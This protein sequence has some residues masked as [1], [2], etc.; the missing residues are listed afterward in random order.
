MCSKDRWAKVYQPLLGLTAEQ[1]RGLL[2]QVREIRNGLAHFRHDVTADEH[3]ALRFCADWLGNHMPGIPVGW[4][5]ADGAAV[6][7]EA[8]E[9]VGVA[10]AMR[11]AL[12][13]A[14]DGTEP[15]VTPDQVATVEEMIDRAK[16]AM[17]AWRSG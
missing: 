14:V 12:S 11:L 9:E 1:V 13:S 6:D 8:A 15:S 4:P 17:L 7:V 16:A 5:V 3:D 10:E 2:D